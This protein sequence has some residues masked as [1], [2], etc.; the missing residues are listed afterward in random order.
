MRAKPAHK[1]PVVITHGTAALREM[2][3]LSASLRHAT[4]LT[5]DGFEV[6]SIPRNKTDGRLASMASSIQALSEA[7]AGEL[8]IGASQYVIIASETGHVIQLRI[9]GQQLVLAG[10]FDDDE[11]LG[12]ALSTS[13]LVAEKLAAALISR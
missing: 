6:V 12:K 9:P 4:L 3:E 11:T 5:D 10:L 13:R 1:D 8:D 7:V 2:S